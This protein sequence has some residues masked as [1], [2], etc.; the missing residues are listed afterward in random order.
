MCF[1]LF[2][3]LSCSQGFLVIDDSVFVINYGIYSLY[4]QIVTLN[5]LVIK[6][7]RKDKTVIE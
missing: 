7:R 1:D 2:D 6:N 3:Q 5:T 4:V